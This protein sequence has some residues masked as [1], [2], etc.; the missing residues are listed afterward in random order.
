MKLNA[1]AF[2][3]HN[4]ERVAVAFILESETWPVFVAWARQHAISPEAI[5]YFARPD[6]EDAQYMYVLH[7]PDETVAAIAETLNEFFNTED[8]DGTAQDN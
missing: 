4:L 7:S 5:A 8:E 2:G 6:Y 1:G 3:Y